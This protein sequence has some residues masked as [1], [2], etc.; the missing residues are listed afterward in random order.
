[1]SGHA[2]DKSYI[3]SQV[4][5]HTETLALLRKEIASGHD[6]DAK[7]FAR[8]IMPTVRSHLKAIRQL[9]SEEGA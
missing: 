3:K 8:S 5:A 2:F 1:L 6:A 4:K 9:A 7:A